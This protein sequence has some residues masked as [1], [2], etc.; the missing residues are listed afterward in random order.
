MIFM[1]IHWTELGPDCDQGPC[2]YAESLTYHD[3]DSNCNIVLNIQ[4][5]YNMRMQVIFFYSNFLDRII[6][7]SNPKPLKLCRESEFNDWRG[8][9]YLYILNGA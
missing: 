1:Q 7:E 3:W 9:P 5:D 8:C 4:L 6:V 2:R